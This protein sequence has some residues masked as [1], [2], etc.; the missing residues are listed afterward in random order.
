M[1]RTYYQFHF[2]MQEHDLLVLVLVFVA[3]LRRGDAARE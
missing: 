1:G 2:T 3:Q